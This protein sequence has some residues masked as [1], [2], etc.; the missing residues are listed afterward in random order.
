M[1]AIRNVLKTGLDSHPALVALRKL[2]LT[3]IA[4]DYILTFKRK[5]GGGTYRLAAALANGSN[6]IAKRCRRN[7]GVLERAVY[8]HV[9]S[10][11]PVPPLDYYGSVEDDDGR[12][13]WLFLQDVGDE[14]YAPSDRTSRTLAAQWFG[15][16][17]AAVA[18]DELSFPFPD[19]GADSYA[20]GLRAIIESI[21]ELRERRSI[22]R[23]GGD[24]LK[25]IAASCL[26]IQ[27]RWNYV[28][29]LCASVPSVFSHNDCLPKNIHVRRN[30]L[31]PS[32]VPFDW[33]GAGWAP[34]GAD[35]G[36]LALPESGP[37]TESPNCAAYT[38]ALAERWPQLENDAIVR[39][40]LLGQLC[41]SIKVIS[42]ALPEFDCDWQK[43]EYVVS[44]LEVYERALA[45][46]QSIFSNAVGS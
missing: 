41:W 37:P 34:A 3:R 32:I 24:V 4:P 12:W 42:R 7:K 43:P 21:V 44:N 10:R 36:L 29:E 22:M 13:M 28:V 5:E 25:R 45:R 11:L 46:S 1:V 30:E 6:V 20:D 15:E 38:R 19:R 9:L 8:E 39:S 40:A 18:R 35:L 31:G 23:L 16:M 33:G 2:E 26:D 17:Q 27:S 14:R